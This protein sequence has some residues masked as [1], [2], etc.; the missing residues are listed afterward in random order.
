[1]STAPLLQVALDFVSTPAALAMALKVA[2]AVDII[3]IGT[4][5]CKAAGMDA[6]RSV[7]EVCPDKLILADLKSPDVGGARPAI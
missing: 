7:R 3:E 6:V 2:P 5:L 4:P 1:M